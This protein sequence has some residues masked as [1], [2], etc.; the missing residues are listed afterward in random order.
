MTGSAMASGVPSSRCM[1]STRAV[2][3]DSC[4]VG[5]RTPPSA[6]APA[7]AATAARL[8]ASMRKSS[9]SRTAPAKALASSRVP[10][11]RPHRLRASTVLASRAT[12][13]RSRSTTERMPGRWTFTTTSAPDGS[14]AACTCAT[15]AAASGRRS[16]W[17]NTSSGGPPSSAASTRST[18][19][20]GAGAA[21]SRSRP[22][23][24]TSS[25]GSRSGRVESTWPSFTKVTPPS[26]SACRTDRASRARPPGASS[27]ARRRPRR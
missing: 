21:W 16:K 2:H 18:S 15:D 23:S 14:R 12:M 4:G 8:P 3:R 26:S 5:T 10:I 13:S 19:G 17:A 1:T 27:S 22:S 6:A 24:S 11:E 7:A 9:S 25:S 20:H